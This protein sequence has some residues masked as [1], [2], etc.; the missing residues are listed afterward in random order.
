MKSIALMSHQAYALMNFRKSLILKL[1]DR[2]IKVYALA[3]DFSAIQI[4]TLN[5]WG[6]IPIS[7]SLSRT[8]SNPFKDFLDTIS[9]IALFKKLRVDV[10]FGFAIKPVIFGTLAAWLARVPHRVAMIE[11]LGYLFTNDNRGKAYKKKALL[12]IACLLYKM[13]LSKASEVIFLNQDDISYF[14]NHHLV[15]DGRAINLD[16]IG[17]D[18]NAWQKSAPTLDPVTFIFVGRLLREKGVL[19]YIAAIKQLRSEGIAARFLLLGDT[20]SNPSAIPI[21][22]I[23]EWV[24]SEGIEWLG[25]TDVKPW[26][27][28]SSVFV[29]PSY[30]EGIPR[31][32]LEA[33]SMGR[34]VITTDVP[35]CKE[36]VINGVNGYLIPPFDVEALTKAMKHFIHNPQLI[37][38]MGVQSRAIAERRFD[39]ID[40]DNFLMKLLHLESNL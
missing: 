17:I 12:I 14:E 22:S 36:T 11:G 37:E 30:R 2:G 27:G 23:K 31:S 33:M 16:G 7:Y 9:L 6:A 39:V 26:L 4:E 35:G 13:S 38:V 25:H 19:E 32:T 1:I 24:E 40:K 21:E 5:R 10:F 18:L 15:E 29:L 20:D 28:K 34:P 3:P 8:G